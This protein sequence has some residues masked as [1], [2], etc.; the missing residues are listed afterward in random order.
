MATPGHIAITTSGTKTR[1][2]IDPTTYSKVDITDFAPRAV[3]GTPAFSTLG[4][5][6]DVAQDGFRHGFGKEEFSE[7]VSYSYVGHQVD[8][9]HDFISLWTNFTTAIAAT[10]GLV[11]TKYIKFSGFD[12][13]GTTAGISIFQTDD[14]TVKDLAFTAV[15]DI[16]SNGKYLFLS[17]GTRMKIAWLGQPSS[18]TSTT[19]TFSAAAFETTDQ[20]AT[21]GKAWVFEGTGS[22]AEATIT[23]STGTVVTV[24]SWPS[25]TPNT[26][27]YILLIADAGNA[28]NPP[29]NFSKMA[30]FGGSMWAVQSSTRFLHFWSEINGTDAEGGGLTDAGAITVG[31]P[32]AIIRSL[33]PYQ[34]QLWAFRDDGAWTINEQDVDGLAYHT[35]DVSAQASTQNFL[36][37]IV[38]NGFLIYPVRNT[39]MKYRSGEQDISPPTFGFKHPPKRFGWFRGFAARGRFLFL[40]AKSNEAFSDES[41]EASAGFVSLLCHDGVGWHKLMDIPI[42]AP[43]SANMWLDAEDDYLWIYANDPSVGKGSVYKIQLQTNTDL[44]FASYPTTGDHNLYTSYYFLDMRRVSKSFASLTM[45]GE[46]PSGATVIVSYRLDAATSWTSLGTFSSDMQEV[47]FGATVTG[48]R[49]QFR[50]NLQTSTSTNTPLIK[51]LILKTML[52]P[53]VLYGVSCDVIVSDDVTDQAQLKLGSTA[54]EVRAALLAA[55]NSVPPITFQDIHG[56]SASAYLSSLRFLTIQYEDSDKVQELARVTIVYV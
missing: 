43:N 37:T 40:L 30:I 12:I 38:W 31:P 47:A 4:L 16:I 46:F 49:V 52:R 48:K 55:R 1:L 27:S 35:L 51:T 32:G 45:R 5:Y 25:G 23:A 13:L 36:S 39:L 54:K 42:A 9:R 15:R 19:A 44:P 22:V 3:T 33:Q 26:G 20:W 50:L 6:L 28:G 2:L 21:N 24:S 53:Q 8:T 34:N 18:T 29:N 17:T 11:V 41:T 7:P 56:D 10:T 14:T